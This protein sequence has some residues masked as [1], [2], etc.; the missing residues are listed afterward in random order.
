MTEILWELRSDKVLSSIK[1]GK[2]LD[3]RKFDEYRKIEFRKEF[4]ENAEGSAVVKIGETE[5]VAGVKMLPD[6]PYPDTPDQGTISVGAELLPIAS[7]SF[8]S[9]PPSGQSIELARVVDRGIRESKA[10]DFKELCIREGELSWIVFIDVYA[11]NDSGNL[12]DASSIAALLSLIDAKIPKIEDDKV[13]KK[14]YSGKLKLSRKPLLS[15]FA[16]LNNSI[17]LDPNTAEEKSSSA[18]FSVATTEDDF[19]CAFQKG[20]SGSF[21]MKEIDEMIDSALK[22]GKNVRKTLKV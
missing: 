13:V 16:K 22:Q 1:E 6:K 20:G 8:E 5:V 12:F 10:L 17:V 2:R 19:L 14:E 9:G 7:P 21:S 18:R 15:T 4:S 3:L 11:L